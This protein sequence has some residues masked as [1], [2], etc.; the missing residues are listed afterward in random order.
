MKYSKIGDREAF[1]NLA[2][3]SNLFQN[4]QHLNSMEASKLIYCFS[5]IKIQDKKIWN[6]LENL[7]FN[8]E[9]NMNMHDYIMCTWAFSKNSKNPMIW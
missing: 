8:K 9:K 2:Q 4:L 6:I 7:F 5:N 3:K 1:F